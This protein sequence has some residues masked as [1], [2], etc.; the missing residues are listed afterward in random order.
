M[1]NVDTVSKEYGSAP[2]CSTDVD[3][4]YLTILSHTMVRYQHCMPGPY[5]MHNCV[6]F[7]INPFMPELIFMVHK[8]GKIKMGL[9]IQICHSKMFHSSTNMP[10]D[11]EKPLTKMSC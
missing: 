4:G 10:H 1:W 6:L 5:T 11:N 9:H 8:L 7:F 3:V 2:I